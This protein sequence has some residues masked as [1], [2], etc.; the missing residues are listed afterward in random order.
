MTRTPSVRPP[1]WERSKLVTPSLSPVN[2]EKIK[3]KQ[4]VTLSAFR[5]S[6]DANDWDQINSAHFD[7][8]M[9]PIDDGRLKE[10][11]LKSEEDVKSLRDDETWL[12]R[13]RESIRL[14]ARALGWDVKL[15]RPCDDES[16][17]RWEEIPYNN[18]DVR[19]A[20]MIRS[21][22]LMEDYELFESLQSFA[23][24]INTKIYFGDGFW[25][26]DISLDEILFMTLPRT[27]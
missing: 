3:D 11:N 1:L 5:R 16:S 9:F 7:W 25:Y 15:S 6:A 2:V 10:F 19:L 12:E 23:R 8:W 24:Y 27:E 20:K 18:K 17:P 21:A 22:W 13:Y 26:G 4:S 14:V